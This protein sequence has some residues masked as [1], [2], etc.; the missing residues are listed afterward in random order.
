MFNKKQ[1]IYDFLNKRKL[2]VLSTVSAKREPSAAVM[3]FV[4]APDLTL[5]FDTANTT[6]KYANLQKNPRV[7]LAF[8]WEEWD[9]VQY[10][11]VAKEL[12]GEEK[13]R[14]RNVFLAKHPDAI[15]WD[16][17]PATTYFKVTPTRIRYTAMD[18]KPWEIV[19]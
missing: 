3:E 15:K 1:F 17:H 19:F 5:I 14:F 9:T 8:G 7:A 13:E 11:G 2:T 16:A 10:E 18:A 12:R 4:V 6:R